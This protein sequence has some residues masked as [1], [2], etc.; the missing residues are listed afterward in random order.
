MPDKSAVATHY[1]HG[2]LLEAIEL[3][4]ETLGLSPETVAVDDLAPGR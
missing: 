3:G 4:M 1:G 2:N